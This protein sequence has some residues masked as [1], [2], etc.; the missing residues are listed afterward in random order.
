MNKLYKIKV[1][2]GAPKDSH[3][4]IECYLVAKDDLKVAKWIDKNKCHGCWSETEE[5]DWFIEGGSDDG[6]TL[7]E[8][9]MANNGDLEDEN[10]WEDAYYGVTKWGWEDLGEIT[11][12]EIKV[13]KKF[14]ILGKS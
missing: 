6:V 9:I 12:E 13:L 8:Y 3:E 4:S 7:W 10:G 11:K 1:L 2:H 5:T 14:D